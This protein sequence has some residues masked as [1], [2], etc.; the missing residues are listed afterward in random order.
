SSDLTSFNADGS[1]SGYDLQQIISSSD[2]SSEAF[3]LTLYSRSGILQPSG[4]QWLLGNDITLDCGS[5][6]AELTS[7]V[8]AAEVVRLELQVSGTALVLNELLCRSAEDDVAQNCDGE[9]E[10]EW[11]IAPF[12]SD[13]GLAVASMCLLYRT[14]N[15]SPYELLRLE[16]G[17]TGFTYT[18]GQRYDLTV[19]QTLTN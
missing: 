15:S 16:E 7:A 2:R 18:W 14:D 12:M 5:N 1:P 10:Q 4:A 3:A 19:R 11:Q 8:N 6:C 9:S 13:C 17:I